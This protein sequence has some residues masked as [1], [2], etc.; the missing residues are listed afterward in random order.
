MQ[1]LTVVR[2][3]VESSARLLCFP[4]SITDRGEGLFGALKTTLVCS[5]LQEALVVMDQK[6]AFFVAAIQNL[7]KSL[8]LV[9]HFRLVLSSPRRLLP[10][11]L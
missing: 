8:T 7:W 2:S 3:T 10:G 1:A 9:Q 6:Q 5:F 11:S 4:L